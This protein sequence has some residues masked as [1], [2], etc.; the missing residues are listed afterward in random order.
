MSESLYDSHNPF[1]HLLGT[2]WLLAKF[3]YNL[4]M[5]YRVAKIS[6]TNELI[7][8]KFAKTD[9]IQG[10]KFLINNLRILNIL[11]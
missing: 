9:K 5:I 11:V 7:L 3:P 2:F 8:I 4:E 10:Y 6:Q 1:G